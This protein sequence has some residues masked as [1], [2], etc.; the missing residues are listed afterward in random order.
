MRLLEKLRVW[1]RLHKSG[2]IGRRVYIV[3]CVGLYNGGHQRRRMSPRSQ[4]ALLDRLSRFARHENIRITAVFEGRPLRKV[5]DGEIYRDVM[6]Y[7]AGRPAALGDLIVR[8]Y[9]DAARRDEV[10]VITSDRRLEERVVMSGGKTMR[11]STFRKAMEPVAGSQERSGK[12]RSRRRRRSSTDS[13]GR[14]REGASRPKDKD[15]VSELIDIV[16]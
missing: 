6:V 12:R 13:T 1:W 3:D 9:Q 8:L 11:A 2:E 14:Q 4:L 7:Y 16:E 15:P 5:G 10:T